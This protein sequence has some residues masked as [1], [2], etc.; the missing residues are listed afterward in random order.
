MVI[1]NRMQSPQ[2]FIQWNGVLNTSC[3]VVLTIFSVIGFYGYLAV[4]NGIHDTVT[5]DLPDEP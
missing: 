5:L 4:G 2:N 3:M 1:E